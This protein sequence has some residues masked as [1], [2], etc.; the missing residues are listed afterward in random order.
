MADF[1]ATD[2]QA[3]RR[4]TGAGMMDAKRALQEADGD[5]DRAKKILRE[6]GLAKAD[7]RSDRENAQGAIAVGTGDGVV[8][9]V[10]LKC[11]TDFVAKSPEFVALTQALADS[12]AARGE[13]AVEDH[14]NEVDDL[15]VVLKENIALGRTVRLAVEDGQVVDTYLHRQDGRGVNGV[16]VVLEGGTEELAHDI[17]VHIAFAKPQY[18]T[19]DEAPAE[20]VEEERQTLLNITKAEGKPEA[21]WPKIVEGRLNAWYK[22]RVLTEQA[23]VRDEQQTVGQVAAGGGA[24][25]VR[26]AQLFIGG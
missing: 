17:A 2:V 13:G 25:V 18:L 21:A 14:K 20:A 9:L 3:L 4:A 26:Y 1:T 12:V 16:A 24:R 15:K 22:D 23:Y 11:E 8:G 6:K 5:P 10:E 19:R 7:E